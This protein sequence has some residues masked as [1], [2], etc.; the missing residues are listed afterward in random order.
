M[1]NVVETYGTNEAV[2]DSDSMTCSNDNDPLSCPE[3]K[4]EDYIQDAML[5]L[6]QKYK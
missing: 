2:S 4:D 3:P 6:N 5:R 1:A